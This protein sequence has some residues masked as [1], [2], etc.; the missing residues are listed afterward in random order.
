MMRTIFIDGE[1]VGLPGCAFSATVDGYGSEAEIEGTVLS[2]DRQMPV[3]LKLAVSAWWVENGAED[4]VEKYESQE[5]ATKECE[6][7]HEL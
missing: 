3:S 7:D 5:Q 2:Y 1:D 6:A 4:A